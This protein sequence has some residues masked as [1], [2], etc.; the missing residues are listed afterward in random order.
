MKELIDFECEFNLS[1]RASGIGGHFQG[2]VEDH[3]PH[4]RREIGSMRSTTWDV[5][6]RIAD[7]E[8]IKR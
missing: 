4:M 7:L 2:C 3:V 8:Q 1:E 6:W 5:T